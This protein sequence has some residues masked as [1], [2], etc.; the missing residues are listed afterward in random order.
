LIGKLY[1]RDL[2]ETVLTKLRK[3]RRL[4]AGERW[5]LA[6]ALVL[7]PLTFCGVYALGVNRWQRV[8]I[9]LTKFRSAS[10]P[11][12]D[13]AENRL[14]EGSEALPDV[15][16][17][18]KRADAIARIVEIAA[19][20]GVYQASCLQKALV[21]SALLRRHRVENEIRFGARK[22]K[23]ELQAHAWVEVGGIALNE[24][25][26]VDHRYSILGELAAPEIN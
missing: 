12:F 13:L 10:G 5:L 11:D 8:L 18:A 25:D 2:V 20:H 17:N 15:G 6:Q 26:G 7:L 24:D 14:R 1:E 23:G 9:K 22:E 19:H 21:L 4:S 16:A 3:V